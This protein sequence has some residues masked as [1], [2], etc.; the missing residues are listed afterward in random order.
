MSRID[1][2]VRSHILALPI[3]KVYLARGEHVFCDH[4]KEH[5]GVCNDLNILNLARLQ[6]LVAVLVGDQAFELIAQMVSDDAD[7]TNFDLAVQ[8]FR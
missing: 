4:F 7:L 5:V 8:F 3:G 6:D 1:S 2:F